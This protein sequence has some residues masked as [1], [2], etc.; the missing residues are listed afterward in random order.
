MFFVHA[1]PALPSAEREAWAGQVVALAC[2][3]GIGR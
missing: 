3:F 2:A 1:L